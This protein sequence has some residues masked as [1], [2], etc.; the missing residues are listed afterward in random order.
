MALK[1]LKKVRMC[2]LMIQRSRLKKRKKNTDANEVI[3]ALFSI[4]ERTK[5]W[6]IYK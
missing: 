3:K 4:E 6:E 2:Q 1:C 5:N